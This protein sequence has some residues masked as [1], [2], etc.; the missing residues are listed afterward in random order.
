VR[1]RQFTQGGVSDQFVLDLIDDIYSAGLDPSLWPSVVKRVVDATGGATGQLV[2]P[3]EN[4][5]RSL[6]APYGFGRDAMEPYALYYHK[7]DVWTQT[8]DALSLPSCTVMTGEQLLSNSDFFRSE[9]YNDYLKS[10]G[11]EKIVACFVDNGKGGDV[12]K[13]SFSVYRPPGSEPFD[14]Q[15]VTFLGRIVPHVRRAIQI[16]WRI[17]DLEHRNATN[18]EVLEHL[19]IGVALIDEARKVSYL[20]PVAQ[21]MANAGDGLSVT[22]GELTSALGEETVELSRLLGETVR[23]TVSLECSRTGTMAVSRR[24][25]QLPYRITAIPVPTTGAFAIGRQQTAAIVFISEAQ[26]APKSSVDLIA[27]I[28]S[29]SESESRLL[30]SLM[31]CQPLKLAARSLGISVNTAHTQ[32]NNI[33]RKTGVHR[34]PEL[35]R[36]AMSLAGPLKQ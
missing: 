10:H 11:F 19:N 17:H 14:R 12:P 29:L 21:S 33:F 22:D 1:Q 32:L 9:F 8:A 4:A 5:T 6:W 7:L 25:G 18:T 27:N 28:Y 2:S 16:H 31:E 24:S 15:A 13:T 20:N 23:A 36:L 34:Q 35:V 26:L 30:R 3:N